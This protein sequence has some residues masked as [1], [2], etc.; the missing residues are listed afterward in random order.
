V[1]LLSGTK[2]RSTSHARE[3]S[4]LYSERSTRWPTVSSRRPGPAEPS[5]ELLSRLGNLKPTPLATTAYRHLAAGR[6]PLSGEGAR[7]H[8]GRWNPPESFPTIYLGLCE[9][10]VDAEF[11]RTA[12]KQARHPDD[13]LPRDFVA[14]RVELAEVI[15]LRVKRDPTGTTTLSG[16]SD[17]R[18]PHDDPSLRRRCPRARLRRD[19]RSYPRS[20][21]FSPSFRSGSGSRRARGRRASHALIGRPRRDQRDPPQRRRQ[22]GAHTWHTEPV[23]RGDFAQPCA[24]A[25]THRIARNDGVRGSSPRVGFV[26]GLEYGD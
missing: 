22:D 24:F 3:T 13:F 20:A 9:T 4:A 1:R 5:R 7:I 21:M 2:S 10:T 23:L 14:I 18:R 8:G 16:R 26:G 25:S 15:D 6:D 11:A 12:A 17:D 19:R